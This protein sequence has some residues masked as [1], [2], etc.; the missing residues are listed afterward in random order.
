MIKNIITPI[1][2]VVLVMS[3][4]G[5]P[6]HTNIQDYSNLNLCNAK[7]DIRSSENY[8]KPNLEGY[9]RDCDIIIMRD[10]TR[11]SC[12]IMAK[13]KTEVKT[14]DCPNTGVRA[15]LLIENIASI[16]GVPQ[17]QKKEKRNKNKK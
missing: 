15:I 3:A 17:A 11:I 7:E 12:I 10:S 13:T 6:E 8:S 9:Q 4:Y 16:N 5:M 1:L 14:V 2:L